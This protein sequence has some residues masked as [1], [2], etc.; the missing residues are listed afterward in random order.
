MGGELMAAPFDAGSRRITGPAV[1]L[2]DD[3]SRQMNSTDVAVSETGTLL[4]FGNAVTSTQRE[5]VWVTRDGGAQAVDSSWHG[6]FSDAALSPD[7]TRIAVTTGVTTVV[8]LPSS[9]TPAGGITD[10]WL[11]RFDNGV[12][13]KLT[14][15]GG[16]SRYPAW[17]PNGKSVLYA[18]GANRQSILEK[19]ADGSAP[20][21]VRLRSDDH[22]QAITESPDGQ[23]LIYQSGAANV[24][25]RVYAQHGDSAAAPLLPGKARLPALSPDGRWLAYTSGDNGPA[26]VF[27]VPFPNV[28]AA[29]W[30]VSRRGGVGPF[31]ST[32][33]D[34]LFYAD[35]DRFLVSVPVSTRPTFSSGAPKRLFSTTPYLAHAAISHDDSRFLMVRPLTGASRE[36]LTVYENWAQALQG[37]TK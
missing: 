14:V 7:G 26:E 16:D 13:T 37:K 30:Q 21:K 12:V 22:I 9:R 23:W 4:Y 27:V 29:K 6:E 15:E 17:S 19:P 31:W 28:N 8:D 10:I 25:S 3:L 24:T 35:G 33:G 11:K 2:A 32:R 36:R 1:V 20:P 18:G 34:E 5:L